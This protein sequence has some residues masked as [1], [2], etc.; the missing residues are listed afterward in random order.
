MSIDLRIF[1]GDYRVDVEHIDGEVIGG[2]I[3]FIKDLV[4]RHLLPVA[5]Q[6]DDHIAVF[7]DLLLD[8]TQQV[9]LVHARSCVN[10]S[11]HLCPPQHTHTTSSSIIFLKR[12]L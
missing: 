9:L 12:L 6:T 4:E 1:E 7:F 2:Q 3:H 10:V 5:I 11:V 8:E